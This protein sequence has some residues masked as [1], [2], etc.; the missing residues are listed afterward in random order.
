MVS[1][2][3]STHPVS[4]H[5]FDVTT[6]LT[7][8]LLS[9]TA[10]YNFTAN[11]DL[12][13]GGN[14][15]LWTNAQVSGA[16]Q[17]VYLGLQNGPI[18][19]DQIVLASNH[20]YAV[21]IWVPTDVG[22]FFW[23]KSSAAPQDIGGWYMAGSN[24]SLAVSRFAANSS[25]FGFNGSSQHTWAIALYG[26]PTNAAPTYNGSTNN[27]ANVTTLIIDQFNPT[28]NPYAGTNIY[29]VYDDITN[30]YA[31]DFGSAFSNAVWD[32]TSDAQN[33]PNSG[34]LKITGVFSGGNQYAV[35][36]LGAGAD[37]YPGISPPITNGVGLF[38]FQCDVRFDPSSATTVN[39]SVTNYGHLE[40]GPIPPYN[41]SDDFGSVE[42]PVGT[43][44]WVHV[45]FNL[46][47][48]ADANLLSIGGIFI[49]IN[50]GYYG[51]HAITGTNILWVDNI[52]FTASSSPPAPPAPPT[53]SIA[54]AVP[55]LR[56]FAGSI[57]NNYDREELA[58]M[59]G[60]Q[61]WIGQP[62]ASY[63]FTLL[64]YPANINQTQI[65]LVPTGGSN[66]GG[67]AVYPN[68]YVEYQAANMLWMVINPGPGT[69]VTAFV[70]W[71]TNSP[72]ANPTNT[73]LQ[74]TNSTAVGTWTLAFS[75][76]S[77]GTL[78]APGGTPQSF[79]IGD[80]NV[81]ADFGN[82]LTAYF[83]LQPNSTA[84][85][86][87]YED[88]GSIVVTHVAGVNESE[89][90][91]EEPLGTAAGGGVSA[92]WTNNSAQVASLV[93]VATNDL[94]A[95]WVSWTLPAVNYGLATSMNVNG[96]ANTPL[97]WVTPEYFI[98]YAYG[99]TF[100]S[101]SQQGSKVWSMIPTYGLPTTNGLQYGMG[102]VGPAPSAFFKLI[103]P[104]PAD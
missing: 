21:E 15:L 5:I 95:Y 4:V 37:S 10:T 84:G 67:N 8:G 25:T 65:F 29:A 26:Y 63:S 96:S 60:S 38:T 47:P 86:G 11:G 16:E 53:L 55:E 46:N 74:I 19:Q 36:D 97:P 14:G 98:D 48:A 92:V 66:L 77:T 52:E 87:Q 33:N 91:T 13:G 45:S 62:G 23:Y 3:D 28:N 30:I 56:I 99:D 75:G 18:S 12:L 85:E 104:V 81:V 79:T 73:A 70:Q 34:S 82:P 68:E 39:G 1:G 103:N 9:S 51:T 90:F 31:V 7:G 94:P 93:V 49:K 24:P 83:G 17:Q 80:A 64:D 32:P 50:G 6:N 76:N 57:V 101:Q 78:T 40:F 20:T 88:W 61:S 42:V 44:N 59:D 27:E 22:S 89:D 72:N 58:T 69:N 41:A 43:T 2:Y 100:P 71:K 102:G 54:K 35:T